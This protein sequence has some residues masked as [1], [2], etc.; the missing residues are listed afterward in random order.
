MC[1]CFTQK[2]IFTRSTVD[3]W[4]YLLCKNYVNGYSL[5]VNGCPSIVHCIGQRA[6]ILFTIQW[7]T[8]R[9][10]SPFNWTILRFA[11]AVPKYPEGVSG[12]KINVQKWNDSITTINRSQTIPFITINLTWA[13]EKSSMKSLAN[14][15]AR[16]CLHRS[17]LI[18]SN[19]NYKPNPKQSLMKMF[20]G[21]CA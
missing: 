6:S 2:K 13:N 19:K 3:F 15:F 9:V 21:Y 17:V 20:I 12:R 11:I 16:V 18:T 14:P 5:S 8:I 7:M 1:K 10:R 4:G